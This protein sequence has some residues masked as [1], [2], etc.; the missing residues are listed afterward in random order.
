M[1]CREPKIQF[2]SVKGKPLD[3]HVEDFRRLRP[4]SWLNDEIINGYGILINI[5]TGSDIVIMQSFFMH[6]L[7]HEGYRSVN[8]WLK[9]SL[10]L[11]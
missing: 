2:R 8:R 10:N 11:G 3:I 4:M 6:K 1:R 7:A 5:A 9:V